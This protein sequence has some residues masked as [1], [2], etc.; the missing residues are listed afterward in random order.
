M[1][2]GI[3]SFRH[4]CKVEE[5]ISSRL[6]CHSVTSLRSSIIIPTRRRAQLL[7]KT[8]G[9]LASQTESDFEVVVVCDGEDEQTQL[10]GERYESRFPLTWLFGEKQQGP[11]SARNIGAQAASGDILLFLDDDTSA[12]ADLLFHH[13]KHHEANRSGAPLAVY[14][15][16]VNTYPE[17]PANGTERF[18]RK[19]NEESFKE[20]EVDLADTTFSRLRSDA[21][22]YRSFGVNCSIRRDTFLKFG[23]FDP[24]LMVDEDMELGS[25]LYDRG[26]CF[27]LEPGA[28][29]NH[30]DTKELQDYWVRCWQATG[31]NHLYRILVKQQR[32]AQT[33]GLDRVGRRRSLSKA[34]AWVACN[35][36]KQISELAKLA[37]KV[38]EAT[39]WDGVFRIWMKL[40]M[41]ANYWDGIRSEGFTWKSL[42]DI[43][44]SPLPVFAFH[45]ICVPRE[46]RERPYYLSPRRFQRFLKVL[47]ALSYTSVTPEEG[48]SAQVPHSRC[49]LTFDDGYDDFYAEVFPHVSTF[50]LK[51]LVFL[52]VDQIGKTNSWDA[53]LKY[54]FPRKLLSIEQIR[55][56]HRHG[57]LFGSHTLS[58]PSLPS[59]SE[60]ALRREVRESKARLEDLLGSEVTNFA[61][62]YGD[63]DLR[64]RTAVGE[65]G[66]KLAFSIE[67]GSNLWHDPLAL[68]R[69][70]LSDRDTY[71]GT[72]LK[73]TTD[74]SL[75]SLFSANAAI[76]RIVAHLPP[77]L[78]E[79]MRNVRAR[80]LRL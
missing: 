41:A 29:V 18:L 77:Q 71:L 60:A 38:A 26:I 34:K 39:Q 63:L 5:Y 19:Q 32:N 9:S 64:V 35:Y 53:H 75:E 56:M 62:P 7:S 17:E 50:R 36:P 28:L 37:Q 58:H 25:R 11:A 67:P 12:D 4:L 2:G 46:R 78:A 48:L 76:R 23:G 33:K 24:R 49:V 70:E 54:R 14:G 80:G 73:L 20:F 43:V 55:E 45:S 65:A 22:R 74:R 69:I 21:H 16:I 30:R 31:H 72:L 59:L 52:V 68:R 40:A 42:Q 79:A 15:K 27:V 3:G 51:P 66:Y 57:V 47:R 6:P 8:L 44:G 1:H 13:R 61:Y 10:L